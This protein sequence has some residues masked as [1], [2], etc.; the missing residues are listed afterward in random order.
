[1]IAEQQQKRIL[2]SEGWSGIQFQLHML[3]QT[4]HIKEETQPVKTRGEKMRG[5][6]VQMECSR[7]HGIRQG[8]LLL[9]K[10]DLEITGANGVLLGG[11][12]KC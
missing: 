9:L 3:L 1:M 10:V 8:K 12:S 5:L 6:K 2:T 7:S 4:V 11:D